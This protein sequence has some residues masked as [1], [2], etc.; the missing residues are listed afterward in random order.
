[1][2]KENHKKKQNH[3]SISSGRERVAIVIRSTKSKNHF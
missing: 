1:M 3:H 2:Q